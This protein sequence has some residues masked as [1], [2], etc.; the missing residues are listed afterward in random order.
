M[1][2]GCVTM[3]GCMIL[4]PSAQGNAKDC[5][6]GGDCGDGGCIGATA[7]AD[8]LFSKPPG[9]D[10]LLGG[11]YLCGE[12]DCWVS[13]QRFLM[14]CPYSRRMELTPLVDLSG[15]MSTMETRMALP[16]QIFRI[17]TSSVGSSSKTSRLRGTYGS[18]FV[19]LRRRSRIGIIRWL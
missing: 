2:H 15:L 17:Q 3:G 14:A 1:I 9:F 12:C 19:A 11:T 7:C 18:R 4:L 10:K 6:Q 8:N 16:Q 13:I 5:R